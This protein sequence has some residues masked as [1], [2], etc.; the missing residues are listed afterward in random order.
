MMYVY[1]YAELITCWVWRRVRW[2]V[3]WSCDFVRHSQ[4]CFVNLLPFCSRSIVSCYSSLTLPLPP[5]MFTSHPERRLPSPSFPHQITCILLFASLLFLSPSI[6][7]M[8]TSW[9]ASAATAGYA[10]TPDCLFTRVFVPKDVRVEVTN[11]WVRC[12]I[13]LSVPGLPH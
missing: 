3:W 12:D 8:S 4:C 5:S 7:A 2:F 1:L 10:F 9:L 6:R 13:C 11:E